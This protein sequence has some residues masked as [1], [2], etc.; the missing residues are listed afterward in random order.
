MPKT[1]V[2]YFSRA[3]QNYVAGDIVELP[4]GNTAIAAEI[5]AHACSGDL[6]EIATKTP[7]A[8]DYHACVEQSRAELA[9]RTRPALRTLPDSIDGYDCIVLGYPNWCGDMPMAVYTFL[10][11]FDFAGKTILPFCTNEGSGASG[12]DRSI[13]RACPGAVVAQPLSI[14]GH[15][16]A[17]AAP[18]IEAWLNANLPK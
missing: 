9:A 5:A 10:E 11:S 2:A 15:E 17:K 18:E 7:Y 12:T 3:G 16:A 13:A 14:T 1:L 4:K 6:F 8:D